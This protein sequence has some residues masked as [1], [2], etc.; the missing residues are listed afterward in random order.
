MRAE[1]IVVVRLLDSDTCRRNFEM[2]GRRLTVGCPPGCCHLGFQAIRQ[3]VPLAAGGQK[4]KLP[5]A[6]NLG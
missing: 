6:E 5:F 4:P 2:V 1:V 3:Q